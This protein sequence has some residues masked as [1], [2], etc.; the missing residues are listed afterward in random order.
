MYKMTWFNFI[1][2]LN[3]IMCEPKPLIISQQCVVYNFKCDLCD[4]EYVGYTSRHLHQ[5]ID[6]HR[7]LTIGKH[8]KN[9]H[10]LETTLQLHVDLSVSFRNGQ[11]RWILCLEGS[12]YSFGHSLRGPPKACWISS[13][14]FVLEKVRSF[15]WRLWSHLKG[16]K[17]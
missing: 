2:G 3:I 12:F 1:L 13:V 7:Y 9:D 8:L 10:S 4:A 14:S 11:Y 16:M 5:R 15:G 6:E 17:Q